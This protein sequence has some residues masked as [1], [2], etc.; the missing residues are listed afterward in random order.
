MAK[1]SIPSLTQ[2]PDSF[3]MSKFMQAMNWLQDALD[4]SKISISQISYKFNFLS[5]SKFMIAM[6]GLQDTLDTSKIFIYKFLYRLIS[7]CV[8]YIDYI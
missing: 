2:M 8:H 5:M 7:H 6:N 1:K 3:T 4:T